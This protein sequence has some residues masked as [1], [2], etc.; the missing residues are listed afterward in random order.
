MN[1]QVKCINP[2]RYKLTKG[3]VY[4]Y[5]A[6][7]NGYYY[8]VN[9]LGKKVKYYQDLFKVVEPEKKK[10]TMQEV[11]NTVNVSFSNSN[12]I[13]VNYRWNE[14]RYSFNCGFNINQGTNISC[15]V[16]QVSNLNG[17]ASQIASTTNCPASLPDRANFL[18]HL[19]SKCISE[20]VNECNAGIVIMSTNTNNNG[21]YE[22]IIS[23]LDDIADSVL[24]TLNPN[25]GNRIS[26][27][28]FDCNAQPEEEED[29]D[30][31]DW[32]DED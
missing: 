15:G 16:K 3:K 26:M 10:D 1:K 21:Q 31:E 4:P 14:R 19:F 13:D 5:T 8:V 29:Y 25:S 23:C 32:D 2:K 24:N 18:R 9:D 22:S 7:R 12:R 28:S 27:W 20:A 17:L 11:L 6:K 30:D